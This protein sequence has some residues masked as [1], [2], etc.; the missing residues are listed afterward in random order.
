MTTKA[1]PSLEEEDE[2]K[3]FKPKTLNNLTI[4][5]CILSLRFLVESL[6]SEIDD[7]N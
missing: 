7:S 4:P 3:N 5:R 6:L 1:S 2:G